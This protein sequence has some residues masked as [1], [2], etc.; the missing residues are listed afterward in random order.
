[1]NIFISVTIFVLKKKVNSQIKVASL[2]PESGVF[3]IIVI[4]TNIMSWG[5]EQLFSQNTS[6]KGV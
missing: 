6:T 1:M 5:L 3:V 2:F 4:I